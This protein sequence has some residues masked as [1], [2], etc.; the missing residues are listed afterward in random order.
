M[1]EALSMIKE[2]QQNSQSPE[3]KSKSKRFLDPKDVSQPPPADDT[4][5][6]KFANLMSSGS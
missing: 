5:A 4:M 6:S 2:I 3:F 1:D